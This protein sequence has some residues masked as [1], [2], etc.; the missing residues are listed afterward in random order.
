MSPTGS[1]SRRFHTGETVLYSVCVCSLRRGLLVFLAGNSKGGQ[2]AHLWLSSSRTTKG[3]LLPPMS[4]AMRFLAQYTF[5]VRWPTSPKSP[6]RLCSHCA[7]G[8]RGQRYKERLREP[9]MISRN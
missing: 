6:V 4:A 8:M 2:T 5:A 1:S 9:L 3:S 7:E